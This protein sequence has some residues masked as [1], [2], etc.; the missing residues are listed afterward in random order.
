M[1]GH[2]YTTARGREVAVL[3]GG[4]AGLTAGLL[5]AEAGVPAVVLEADGQVGGLARTVVRDGLRFDL[6]GHR[7]F[8]RCAP[9]EELWH[10]LLGPELLVRPRLSR[11]LWN[12]RLLSYPLQP[13]DVARQVGP[14]ELGRV[15]ASYLRAAMRRRGREESFEDWVVNRFGRRL[16]EL[17]FR[18]YTEKVWGV[19]TSE[20]RAEWAAQRIRNLSLAAAARAAVAGRRG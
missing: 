3:G 10:D 7:F 5:L 19:P 6:G 17:F 15:G 14:V 2:P 13:G 8:T 4:P 20:I 11:I 9:V 18:S 1:S 12:G 16:F